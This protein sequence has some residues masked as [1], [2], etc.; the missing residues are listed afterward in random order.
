MIFLIGTGV[1]IQILLCISIKIEQ[2]SDCVHLVGSCAFT[3]GKENLEERKK[4]KKNLNDRQQYDT[5]ISRVCIWADGD[6]VLF[7]CVF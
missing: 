6:V 4:G 2:K 5:M 3:V 7:L 1:A